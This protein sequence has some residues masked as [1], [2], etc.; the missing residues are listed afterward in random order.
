M[1]VCILDQAG[2][3]AFDQGLACRPD[4]FLHAIAPFRDGLVVGAEC[5]FAW[6][7]LADLCV[8]QDIAFVLG[9]ARYRKAIHGG[10]AKNDRLDAGKIARLLRGGTFPLAYAYP[11]GM[12]ETR[13]LLR[14]RAYRVRQRAELLT[15]LQILNAQYNLAPFPKR[16]SFAANRTAMKV[17]ERFADPSVQ[18]SAAIN[19]TLIDRLDDL[20][21]DLELYLVRT[22]KVDDL[23]TFSRLRRIPGVG[24]VLALILLDEMPEAHRFDTAGPFL[25]DARLVRCAHESAG[26]RLGAGGT[27]IGNAPLRWAFAEAACLFL[28]SSERAKKWKQKQA[29]QRG[30]GKALATLAA[31]LGRAVDPMLRKGEASDEERFWGGARPAATGSPSRSRPEACDAGHCFSRGTGAATSGRGAG[32]GRLRAARLLG[33][34]DAWPL[35]GTPV[36]RA[37][38]PRLCGRPAEAGVALLRLRRRRQGPGSVAGRDQAA[39][40]RRSPGFGSASEPGGAVAAGTGAVAPGQRS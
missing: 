36:I 40:A 2:S 27:K 8:A 3:V 37:D 5:L 23:Q 21:T 14:R 17:A 31:R 26:K 38:E 12:R 28:R 29:A 22:A 39:A 13:D 9:H 18:K 6:Y 10:K 7:W 20:L 33:R 1:H 4:A 15:H 30:E 32:A 19:L 35:P 34:A 11:Q 24:K 16:L 25:S